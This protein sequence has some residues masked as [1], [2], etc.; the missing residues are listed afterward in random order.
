MSLHGCKVHEAIPWDWL[1]PFF[2]AQLMKPE[3][4]SHLSR[5]CK[6]FSLVIHLF[7]VSAHS[8]WE[9]LNVH[10]WTIWLRVVPL[11]DSIEMTSLFMQIWSSAHQFSSFLADNIEQIE[12]WWGTNNGMISRYWAQNSLA[13]IS[14]SQTWHWTDFRLS[15]SFLA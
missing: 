8:F 4:L 9:V 14:E 13:W 2:G 5:H 1:R 10:I 12:V 15:G 6:F 3:L 7:M 11:A